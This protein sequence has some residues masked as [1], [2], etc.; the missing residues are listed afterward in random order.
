MAKK[1]AAKKTAARKLTKA[2]QA[3]MDELESK[4]AEAEATITYLKD[5]QA[6][7]DGQLDYLRRK[8]KR[9]A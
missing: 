9:Q 1:A 4:L 6:S 3:K 5:Q 7:M 2:Q 8:V